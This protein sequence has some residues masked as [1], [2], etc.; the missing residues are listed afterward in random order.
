MRFLLLLAA[1]AILGCDRSNADKPIE[2]GHV[3]PPAAD[4]GDEEQAIRLAI[5]E[6]NADPARR[7]HGRK[8][9]VRHAPGGDKPEE[10]GAQA[11]R[12]IALNKSAGLIGGPRAAFAERI[13][14]AVQG[15]DV[16]AIST[17]GWAGPA[18]ARNLFT[19]G[20][21]SAERGRALAAKAREANSTSVLVIRDPAARAA[22]VAADRFVAE[23]RSFT[24]PVAVRLVEL[25][26]DKK[27]PADVVFFACPA[28]TA[29]QHRDQFK[30]ALLLFG[31]EDAELPA[32]LAEGDRADGF[33]VATAVDPSGQSGRLAEFAARFREQAKRPPTVAAVLAHDALT[34]WVEAARRADKLEADAI[35]E[36]LLKRDQPFDTLAGPLTFAADHAAVRTAFVGRLSGGEVRPGGP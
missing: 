2:L 4:A 22:G 30:D 28:K 3:S 36:Q 21:H 27:P 14:I 16:I 6:L 15:E 31:D 13:G 23:C 32:L 25:A 1:L 24:P 12:L 18:P 33:L 35:R 9:H 34:V 19:V 26:A 10:W 8:L 11:T 29:V 5:D 7:P 17:A 20:L